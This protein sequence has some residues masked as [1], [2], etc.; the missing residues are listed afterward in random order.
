M[1]VDDRNGAKPLSSIERV[2]CLHCSAGYVKPAGG[3][4][5]SANPGCPE[6]GYVGW[7][8]ELAPVTADAVPTRSFVGRPRRRA[9]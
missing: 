9:G 7:V 3:G 5:V 4:T 1:G 8:L 2:R 6:C